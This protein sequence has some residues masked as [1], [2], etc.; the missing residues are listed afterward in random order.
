MYCVCVGKE[1]SLKKVNS[2]YILKS[3]MTPRMARRALSGSVGSDLDRCQSWPRVDGGGSG[4]TSPTGDGIFFQSANQLTV[5]SIDSFRMTA[6][7]NNADSCATLTSS[8]LDEDCHSV[9][10]PVP[11]DHGNTSQP[12]PPPKPVTKMT[13]QEIAHWIDVRSRLWFPIAFLLFNA[14]YWGFVWI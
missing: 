14:L 1:V 7:G 3:T 11:G 10:I 9:S 2:K 6:G 12:P 13:P 5:N 4:K 8:V